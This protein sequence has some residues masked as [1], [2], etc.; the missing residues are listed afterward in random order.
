MRDPRVSL[1]ACGSNALI[2]GPPEAGAAADSA[3]RCQ[4]RKLALAGTRGRRFLHPA[5]LRRQHVPGVRA[6]RVQLRPELL[7]ARRDT[8]RAPGTVLRRPRVQRRVRVRRR[9]CP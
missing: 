9:S 2:A 6:A 7:S 3:T 1:L 5:V 8:V 4:A